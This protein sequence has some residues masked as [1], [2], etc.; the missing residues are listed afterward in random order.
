M[1]RLLT[2]KAKRSA[3][4]SI[5]FVVGLP[6]PWPALVSIRIRTGSG[7]ACAAW[8]VAANLNVP[9]NHAVIV[10]R[11]V[12]RVAGYRVPGLMLCSGE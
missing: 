5:L 7:P 11:V 8:S 12:M 10:V 9:R 1:P 4:S 6:A 2:R 3:A